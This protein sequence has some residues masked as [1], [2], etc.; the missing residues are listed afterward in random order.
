MRLNT[1]S[2]SKIVSTTPRNH[3]ALDFLR[4]EAKNLILHAGTAH[5]NLIEERIRQLEAVTARVRARNT[6]RQ[7]RNS[8]GVNNVLVEENVYVEGS[9]D[10]AGTNVVPGRG[11]KRDSSHLVAKALAMDSEAGKVE[12]DD[13]QGFFDCNIC[14]EMAR[15]P[16]LTCC[17]HL[18]CWMCFFQLPYVYST[19]KECPVCKGEVTDATVIPIYGNGN[20]NYEK[21][22]ESGLKIPPRPKAQRVESVRQ[23]RGSRGLSH[24]RVAQALGRIR[25]TMGLGDQHG[26][27][28]SSITGSQNPNSNSPVFSR[29]RVRVL[30]EN[31]ASLST[32]GDNNN[33][34]RIFEDFAPSTGPSQQRISAPVLPIGD[35]VINSP[36]S[37][38][39]SSRASD[40]SDSVTRLE[41]LIT[42]TLAE[43]NMHVRPASSSSS[44]QRR[45]SLLRLSDIDTLVSRET[46][47]RRLN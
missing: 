43:I 45:L 16:V 11:C 29:V 42:A 4:S 25:A 27:N 20:W 35:D 38:P 22:L 10:V 2:L 39:S 13:A 17:G 23:R 6:W 26:S 30:S 32:Q 8:V 14:L 24:I 46:R 19:M 9:G 47:R 18:Y 41:N 3:G 33:G 44:S 40:V 37:I 21:E 31:P 36:A 15:E 1:F 7:A 12:K 5:D 34:Q 28:V